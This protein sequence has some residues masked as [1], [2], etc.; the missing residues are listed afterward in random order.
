MKESNLFGT[1]DYFKLSTTGV[2]DDLAIDIQ[3]AIG[4]D[5]SLSLVANNILVT[6]Q[7]DIVTLTGDVNKEQ[8]KM[9]VGDIATMFA[10]DDNVNNDLR[11]VH[12]TNRENM[13]RG[14]L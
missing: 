10:G 3:D 4:Q 5:T 12:N 9:V 11:V 14:D 1:Q 7:G 6:A 2:D 13:T 8:E